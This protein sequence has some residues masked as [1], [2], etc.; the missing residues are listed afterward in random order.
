MPP[1]TRP[2]MRS[3]LRL[4]GHRLLISTHNLTP[5]PINVYRSLSSLDDGT[6]T[7]TGNAAAIAAQIAKIDMATAMAESSMITAPTTALVGYIGRS[8]S[9][10][11]EDDANDD[12]ALVDVDEDDALLLAYV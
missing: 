7:G 3:H 9:G 2:M 8:S 6:G 12:I 1:P 11:Y 4:V 10:D 5:C